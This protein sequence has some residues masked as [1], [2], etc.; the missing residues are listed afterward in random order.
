MK[1]FKKDELKL[2][3]PFYF[4]ALII[5][6]LFILPAFSILYFRGIGF[7]LTQIGF[8]ASSSALAMVLFEIPTGAI[9]DIFGR[10]F[11]VI[12]GAFLSGITV[13]SIFFF[14]DFYLILVLFFLWGAFGTLMSGADEAWIIDLLKHKKRKNLIHEFYTKRYSFMS[15]ALLVSGIVGALLVKKFGLGIIWPVTGGSM[16]LTAIMISF[17]QEHFIRKKQNIKKQTKQLFSH[18]K[19]SM[20]YSLKHKTIFSL[21]LIS[22][23]MMFVYNFAGEI[24]WLPFLQDLGLQEH[25]FGYLFSF[26][27]VSGIFAPHFS[28]LLIKKL[29]GHKNYLFTILIFMALFLFA[30]GFINTLIFALIIYV[31]F[32]SMHDFY[33]PVRDIYF[34]K[35]VPGKMRATITSFNGVVIALAVIIASPLAGFMADK[36]SPQYTIFLGAFILIPAIILYSKIDGGKRG[37]LGLKEK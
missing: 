4:D 19:K 21:I 7:S 33:N 11:S 24:T 10:K 32:M 28:K 29:G 17:G 18:T 6:M 13:F 30:T 36:I 9:A 35:F 2:L 3:W 31:L 16:I 12:L 8:L 25:W 15:A 26:V 5:P 22:I 20:N 37:K 27:M 23:V 34:Q 1:F 14:N